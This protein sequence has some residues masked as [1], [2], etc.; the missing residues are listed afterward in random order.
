MEILR[1]RAL[2]I[3]REVDIRR[4][5]QGLPSRLDLRPEAPE[6]VHRILSDFHQ[7]ARFDGYSGYCHIPYESLSDYIDRNGLPEAET[8]SLFA[9]LAAVRNKH[10]AEKHETLAQRR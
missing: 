1:R 8:R 9:D 3:Q 4:K 7:L 10:V 5:Q 2:Q 6:S